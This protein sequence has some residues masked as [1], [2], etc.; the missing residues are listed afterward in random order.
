MNKLGMILNLDFFDWV[1][2]RL[3]EKGVNPTESEFR[4]FIAQTASE[5]FDTVYFR[6][7]GVGKV[8]YP[9]KVMTPFDTEYRLSGSS[10]GDLIRQWD[11]LAVAVD[12]CKKNNLMVL[13]WITLFDSYCIGLED[14]FFAQRPDLLMRSRDGKNAMRGVPCYACEE[15]RD[16]RMREAIEVSGYGADGIF[17]SMHSHTCCNRMTGDPEGENIFGYNPEVVLAFQQQYGIDILNEEFD[18]FDLY[19]LQ[20]DFLTG[21]LSQVKGLLNK[22]NQKL[23]ATFAWEKDDGIHGTG[24]TMVNIGY[25][26]GREAYPYDHMIGIHFDCEKW[27]GEGLVDGLAA[28]ADFTDEITKV[29]ERTGGGDFYVWVYFNFIKFLKLFKIVKKL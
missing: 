12:A 10:L 8:C 7:S 6:T 23:H 1:R 26:T 18:R 9:S 16:Y 11:P 22:K 15:T 19:K 5:G 28:Q 17:Y 14:A 29:K 3:T 4:D 25:A 24:R 2:N 21:Y 27:I 20:G 13:V